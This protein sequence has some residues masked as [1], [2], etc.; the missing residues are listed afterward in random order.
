MKTVYSI[1][2]TKIGESVLC[3][4][5]IEWTDSLRHARKIT[6]EKADKMPQCDKGKYTYALSEWIVDDCATLEALRKN[7]EDE[8]LELEYIDTIFNAY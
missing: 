7:H 8:T 4:K 5:D 1:E 2:K 3:S 6:N